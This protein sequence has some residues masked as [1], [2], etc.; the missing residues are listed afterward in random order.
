MS[1]SKTGKQIVDDFFKSLQTNS[2]L[3]QDVVTV[4][5][6]LHANDKLTNNEIDRGLEELRKEILDGGLTNYNC[7]MLRDIA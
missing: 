3:N 2:E 1:E 4:I 7:A 5:T 6:S